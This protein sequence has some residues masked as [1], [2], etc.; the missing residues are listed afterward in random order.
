LRAD[1]PDPVQQP[2]P[3]SHARA[4]RKLAAVRAW[5]DGSWAEDLVR[6][7]KALDI[8]NWTLVFGAELLWSALPFII[9]VSSFAN[10]RVDADLSRHIGLDR[11]ASRIASS[12]FRN[13]PHPEALAI[14]TGLLFSFAGVVAVVGS[15][16]ALYERTFEQQL[17]GW[18][19]L[20]RQL[21]WIA[22]LFALLIA[23]GASDGPER[24]AVGGVVGTITAF[25]VVAVF[26]A[27]TMHFLLAGRVRWRSVIRPA[28][29]TAVLWILLSLFSS[30]YFSGV[31][32]DDSR[33]F[34]T[35][36]IVFTF[37]TWF[38]F[39]GAVIVA[40]AAIGGVWER[41]SR[42]PAAPSAGRA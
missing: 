33:T 39:I 2:P 4:R 38:V 12:I 35:V 3:V 14:V 41:R 37:L 31:V 19:G 22:V 42:T 36:G 34:G 32:V 40:G 8:G 13:T 7:L 27:W 24:R 18:R 1:Q 28:L 26:F 25:V 16:Q 17:R 9:L 21:V 30:I 10:R 6:Q 5:Y 11:Q 23:D 29:V 20:P 15:L